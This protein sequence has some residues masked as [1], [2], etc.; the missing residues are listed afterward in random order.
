M[1]PLPQRIKQFYERISVDREAALEELPKLYSADVH[2]IN[3]VVDQRGLEN[4][5]E[6]WKKA[7]RQYKTFEFKDIE[8]TGTEELFSLT[9]SMNIRFALGPVFKTDM[10]TDCHGKDGKVVF[11]R[12]YFDP[13]GAL[14]GP[15]GPID[16][17]YK[18][19]FGFLVA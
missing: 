5:I 17:L 13:L 14:V 2:F 19:I 3:P 18:K 10:S 15:F 9:Y 12:D 1:D 4:F 7:L 6:T 8:V 16:W 11:C